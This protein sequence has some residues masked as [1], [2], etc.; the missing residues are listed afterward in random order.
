MYDSDQ[1]KAIISR[2]DSRSDTDDSADPLK[3]ASDETPIY[4]DSKTC[5]WPVM[6]HVFAGELKSH[7]KKLEDILKIL[8]PITVQVGLGQ[9]IT[10]VLI[11]GVVIPLVLGIFAAILNS[12]MKGGRV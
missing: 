12:V 5:S 6:S 3:D 10:K 8:T 4:C 7:G 2:L 11:I 9:W 1:R